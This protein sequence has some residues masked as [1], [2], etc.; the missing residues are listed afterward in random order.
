[1]D[2]LDV[3]TSALTSPAVGSTVEIVSSRT[4]TTAVHATTLSV[5][6]AH[7]ITIR[8]SN[9]LAVTD[10]VRREK[11]AIATESAKVLQAA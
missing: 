5:L 9:I 6:F 2:T 7:K 1:M 3:T 10:S 4:K 11:P 8:V